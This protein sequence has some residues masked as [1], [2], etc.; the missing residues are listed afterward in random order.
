MA[1]ERIKSIDFIKGFAILL[2]VLGHS[3]QQCNANPF[4]DHLFCYIYCFHMPLFMFVSGLVSYKLVTSNV[5]SEIRSR[6][7]Q[8]LTP[9]FFWAFLGKLILTGTFH[10]SHWW[11]IIIDP[12]QGLWFFWVLFLVCLLYS[13]VSYLVEK[14]YGIG[15]EK[16]QYTK[17]LHNVY[18]F[19]LIIFLY[20]LLQIA[21]IKTFGLDMVAPYL[22]YYWAGMMTRKYF[23]WLKRVL[24]RLCWV[25]VFTYLLLGWFWQFGKAPSFVE[26]PNSLIHV[27][28]S[29]ITAF[30]G[31]FASL[32]LCVKYVSQE[33]TNFL[34]LKMSFIGQRT[35]GIYAIY[36]SFLTLFVVKY[37]RLMNLG[38]SLTL[39]I[40]FFLTVTLS[41]LVHVI[42]EKG[43]ILPQLLLGKVRLNNCLK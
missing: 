7:Y 33:S 9:F 1:T 34:V 24:V 14:M 22:V 29:F 32:S 26:N 28:Y 23:H 20:L 37:I 15:H 12:Q 25:I 42:V 10:A 27:P 43:N 30:C 38:Y 40:T 31:I 18:L 41:I 6:G 21:D 5:L 39:F 11:N 35:L 3:I 2:V 4:K 13:T 8:L 19:T 16:S 36:H 17:K